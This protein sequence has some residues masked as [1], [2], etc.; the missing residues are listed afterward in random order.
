MLSVHR[1]SQNVLVDA[2]IPNTYVRQCSCQEQRTCSN[3]MEQQ[4]IDCLNPCWDRFNGLTERPDQL[5]KCFDDKSE[6]LQAFLTCFE[7][8]IEGCVQNTNGP[9]IPKRNISEI[10]RL[11]EE[12]IS[13]K[14]VSL[15]QSIPIGLKKILDAA[16]DFALCVKNCFLTKNQGGFCFDRYN[17][18]PL[19][20]EKKT[21]KTLRRCTKTI[22]WKKEAGDLCKCSVNAGISDLKEYCSIFELMSRRRQPRSRI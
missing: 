4:A 13:H 19:I 7:H 2:T 14:A 16:G 15:S 8:N 6:L 5:R 18:Q 21:K 12:A 9:M 11:G 17:C 22:N 3:E 1:E 10:F 20:A